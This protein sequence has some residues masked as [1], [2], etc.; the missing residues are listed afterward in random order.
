MQLEDVC[1]NY[2]SS[3][4]CLIKDIKLKL[5]LTFRNDIPTGIW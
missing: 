5:E 3:V 4:H 2:K 1:A